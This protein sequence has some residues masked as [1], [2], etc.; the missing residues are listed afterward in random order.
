MRWLER[1]GFGVL[2][3]GDGVMVSRRDLALQR[4][5]EQHGGPGQVHASE[6]RSEAVQHVY[7]RLG[8]DKH[9][10]ASSG[11]EVERRLSRLLPIV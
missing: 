1:S 7:N 4:P 2:Y 3:N 10:A 5:L 6:E 8:Q 9:R 11:K